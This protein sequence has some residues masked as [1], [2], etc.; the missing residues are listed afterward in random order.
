M[1]YTRLTCTHVCGNL[2]TVNSVSLFYKSTF[3]WQPPDIM[4]VM[5]HAH[6]RNV[7]AEV[8]HL[9]GFDVGLVYITQAQPEGDEQD[10]RLPESRLLLS[11]GAR[12]LQAAIELTHS[13]WFSTGSCDVQPGHTEALCRE[14]HDLKVTVILQKERKICEIQLVVY[15]EKNFTLLDLL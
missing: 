5:S 4:A 8:P 10:Q 13:L 6:N 7:H 14:K 3:Q 15:V 12:P 9:E 1:F 11:Q 2:K